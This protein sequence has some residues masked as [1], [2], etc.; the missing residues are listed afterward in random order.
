MLRLSTC[1][2]LVVC[3]LSLAGPVA[4]GAAQSETTAATVSS[5]HRVRS[6]F[7]IDKSENRNQVHY[8]IRVDARCRPVRDEPVVAYW[9]EREQG[10]NVVLPLTFFERR[11][12]GV[13]GSSV[14]V[15]WQTG[16]GTVRFALRPLP[17][18]PIAIRTFKRDG[19]CMARA[20]TRIGGEFS[21][22]DSVFVQVG[23]LGADYV[24]LHGQ[25]RLGN[26]RRQRLHA[27]RRR[28]GKLTA[29]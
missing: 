15:T 2:V 26:R 9:R 21:R 27:A 4:P 7:H 20:W 6:V 12:Y 22:L 10:P 19:R 24:E 25:D 16:G 23:F 3:A 18:R 29:R 5:A 14:E 1:A 13:K 8:D 11:A 17:E 28:P